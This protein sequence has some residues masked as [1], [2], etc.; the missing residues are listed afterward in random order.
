MRNRIILILL[1]VVFTLGLVFASLEL[2]MLVDNHIQDSMN[3]LSFDQQSNELNINKT[4]LYFE[5]FHLKEIG[6]I[7]LSLIILLI[8]LGFYFGKK[9]LSLLGA[10]AVFIPVFGHFALSMFFLA[11]LGF[12]RVIWIPFTE[13]SPFFMHYGDV[14]YLPNKTLLSIG[15]FFGLSLNKEIAVFFILIG[16]IL[17]MMGVYVWFSTKFFKNNVAKSF[18]Y[19]ISRHPQYLGWIL[20]SYGVFLLPNK[21]T[22]KNSW[23]YP[24]SFP[25]LLSVMIIVAISLLEEINM[26]K[27]YGAE[28]EEFR[29]NTAFMFPLPKWFKRFVKHPMVLFFSTN[30]FSKK[31]HVLVFTSY[32]TVVLVFISFVIFSFTDPRV[33]NPFLHST[34][35]KAIV[36]YID[37]LNNGA[38]RRQKDIAAMELEQYANLSIPYLMKTLKSKDD[39][40]KSLAIRTLRNIKDASVCNELINSCI[41]DSSEMVLEEALRA[42]GV[43]NCKNS[44]DFILRNI[45][46]SSQRIR[47]AAAYA[48]G[49][50]GAKEGVPFLLRQFEGLGKFSKII[51]I[52]S[53]GNV[54]STE[55]IGL[56]HGQLLSSDTDIVVASIVALCKIGSKRSIPHL[57]KLLAL[58]H[59]EVVVYAKQ[60]INKIKVKE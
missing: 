38:L 49:K 9:S 29:R 47:D 43:L 42:I 44:K 53:F 7:C 48:I 25:W 24:D 36:K 2:P 50:T 33:Q 59:W 23:G 54:K 10:F 22:M 21:E 17:F 20:W 12:L 35:Q 28:Y 19:K 15:E 37:Q 56:L 31:R 60:V 45:Q 4:M 11:G 40:T 58:N 5:Y 41:R 6:Y 18:I 46:H 3:F 14:V 55:A 52:E 27:K 51:Y 30:E 34:K 39:N 1:S 8:F 13:I 26:R 16:I 57:E 32:Y